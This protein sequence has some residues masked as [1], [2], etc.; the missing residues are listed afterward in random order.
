MDPAAPDGTE[1]VNLHPVPES[2][3]TA[4]AAASPYASRLMEDGLYGLDPPRYSLLV[5][6]SADR[7]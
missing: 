7:E 4:K 2:V 5:T 6:G 1:P 3:A